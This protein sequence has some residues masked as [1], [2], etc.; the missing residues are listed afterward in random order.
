M[1]NE[2]FARYGRRFQSP[3]LQSYFN[4]QPWYRPMYAPEK[5]PEEVLTPTELH[6]VQYIR[7]FQIRV[8][9]GSNSSQNLSNSLADTQCDNT[10][11]LVS[12]PN[13]PINVRMGRGVEHKIVGTLDNGI[14][15]TVTREE[16]GWLQI[17][18]PIAGWVA[19]NRTKSICFF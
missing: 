18:E 7:D 14:Q 1:R 5:F 8:A 15:I 13:P 4:S 17:S 10:K 12:D 3:E 16:R 11:R 6:N 2:V 19:A 9:K